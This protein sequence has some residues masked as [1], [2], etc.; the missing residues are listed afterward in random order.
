MGHTTPSRLVLRQNTFA[1]RG[2][3]G[4]EVRC[5]C[6]PP[7]FLQG[8]RFVIAPPAHV[9][10]AVFVATLLRK[11]WFPLGLWPCGRASHSW[12]LYVSS[13]G[14][15]RLFSGGPWAQPYSI[16]RCVMSC[17]RGTCLLGCFGPCPWSSKPRE[18]IQTCNIFGKLLQW[19]GL[20]G[21]RLLIRNRGSVVPWWPK[22][23]R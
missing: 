18:M 9:E 3:G 19:F 23:P 12:G 15:G 1:F 8:G 7:R 16:Q 5:G 21:D 17:L 2:R 20:C 4:C 14:S 13:C 10:V 22:W 6:M 11:H